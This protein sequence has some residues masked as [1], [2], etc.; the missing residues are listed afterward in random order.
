MAWSLF[1]TAVRWSVA[2]SS[3]SAEAP[4]GTTRWAK[5]EAQLS[6]KANHP[7]VTTV[8]V[9]KAFLSEFTNRYVIKAGFLDGT[10]GLIEA[11]FQGL[12]QCAKLTYLWELQNDNQK[13]F[14][15]ACLAD[16]QAQNV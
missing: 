11:L 9:I 5:I 1:Q 3:C 4:C 6:F 12:H 7:K 10:V 14:Q 8:K 13:K 15:S 2:C 16:R